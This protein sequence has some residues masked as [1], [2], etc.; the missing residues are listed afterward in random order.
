V[1]ETREGKN[2]TRRK[3]GLPLENKHDVQGTTEE[4]I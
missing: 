3:M 1:D 2:E 4:T